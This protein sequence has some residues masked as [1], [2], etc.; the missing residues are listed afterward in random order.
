MSTPEEEEPPG[1]EEFVATLTKFGEERG[2]VVTWIKRP[3]F[4]WATADLSDSQNKRGL[5]SACQY[6]AYRPLEAMEC[7]VIEGRIRCCQRRKAGVAE[8]GAGVQSGDC[9]R[10]GLCFCSE[11][12][13]L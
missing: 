1:R 6:K 4:L 8:S 11:D 2:Y 3:H 10:S 9:K 13:I 12:N 7:G 5:P